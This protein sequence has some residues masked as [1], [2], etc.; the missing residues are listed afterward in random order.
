MPSDFEIRYRGIA[1]D[2]EIGASW[3][4]VVADAGPCEHI[5]QLY[6]DQDF[7]NRAVCRF[8]GAALA[9]G[10]GLILVPTL[11]HWSNIRPRLEAEGVDV[12]A[13][14]GRGQLTVVDA[15]QLLPRFM[16]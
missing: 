14:Q 13:A 12:E 15:D 9:N 8:A 1:M 2:H 5:V 16:R 4:R 3:E 7:L 6:Q 10:E 11:E